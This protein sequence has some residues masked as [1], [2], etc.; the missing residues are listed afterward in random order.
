MI[1]MLLECYNKA[2]INL[3]NYLFTTEH[4]CGRYTLRDTEKIA[5]RFDVSGKVPK[6]K[7]NFN[8]APTHIMPVI[9]QKDGKNRLEMMSWGIIPVWA[10]DKP[11]FAY[12]TFNAKAETLEEKPMWKG[13]FHK[14]R[15]LVP[16][17]GYYEWQKLAGDKKQTYYFHL[18]D[19]KMFAFAGLY[20]SFTDEKTG[21]I[22][23]SY[24]IIT[25][26]PNK[27]QAP[28]HDRMPVILDP[29]EESV[30]LEPTDEFGHLETILDPYKVTGFEHYPVKSDVGNVRNNSA[31]LIEHI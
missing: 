4:G 13:L 5:K 24:T 9:T 22:F 15:C 19:D 14:T 16:A 17:D 8:T 20:T 18:A 27:I 2:M 3:D 1:F 31:E 30:W 11:Q 10:K 7:P 25:T 21:E 23:S 26:R 6:L 12:T 28:I 29:D